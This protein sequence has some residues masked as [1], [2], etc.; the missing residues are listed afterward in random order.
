MNI[1][2]L[3]KKEINQCPWRA[4]HNRVT[5]RIKLMPFNLHETALFIDA[6]GAKLTPTRL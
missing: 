3:D 2:I 6:L 5:Q 4:V 1:I